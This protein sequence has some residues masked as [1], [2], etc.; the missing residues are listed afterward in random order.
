M[1]SEPLTQVIETI[2]ADI[3]HLALP[4]P[5]PVGPVNAYLLLGDRLT[6]VDPGMVWGDTTD[7]ITDRLASDLGIDFAAANELEI[8]DGKLTGRIVGAVVD[9]VVRHARCSV[10]V[11]RR[12]EHSHDASTHE[13]HA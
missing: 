1:S 10:L 4:T 12:P 5:F 13:H 8:V 7:Q 11:D 9:R 3:D 6:I 2:P